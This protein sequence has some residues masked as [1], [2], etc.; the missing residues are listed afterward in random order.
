M[1]CSQVVVEKKWAISVDQC[2]LQALRFWVHLIS[3]LSVLLLCNGFAGIQKSCCGSDWQQTTRQWSGPFLVWVWE[4][5]CSC[6]SVQ[7]L[8]LVVA[9]YHVQSTLHRMLWSDQF[10]DRFVAQNKRRWHFRT[11]C[12][13]FCFNFWSGHEALWRRR[14]QPTPVFLPG[15]FHGQR[16]PAAYSPWGHKESDTKEQLN[17]QE[18]LTYQAF[19][20]FRFASNAQRP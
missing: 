11:M 6:L 7:L 20:P 14:W 4:V 1:K 9:S 5:L 8:K 13:C 16:S 10:V 12:C 3:L 19:S 2:Q 15:E 18:T 17:T